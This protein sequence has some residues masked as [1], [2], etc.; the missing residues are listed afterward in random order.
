M[1][2]GERNVLMQVKEGDNMGRRRARRN[3]YNY[4]LTGHRGE[5]LGHGIT[6]DPEREKQNIEP[7]VKDS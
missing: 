6:N 3:T 1:E 5:D 7:L 4:T 2:R